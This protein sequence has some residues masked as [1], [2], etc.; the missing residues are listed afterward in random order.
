MDN[1]LVQ[2]DPGLF[3]WTILTFLVLLTLLAK[4]AWRTSAA[5]ARQPS[6][7]RSASRS[8]MPSR[9]SRSWSGCSRNRR[10][11]SGRR[12]SRP[13]R[14][15]RAAAADAERLREE[16]RQKA[17]AEAETIVRNAERQIQLETET[18]APADPPRGG[19]SVGDD[20]VEDHPAESLEGRQRAADRRSA[21]AGRRPSHQ[22]ELA[23]RGS[24]AGWG[25]DPVSSRVRL[26]NF[27][28]SHPHGENKTKAAKPHHRNVFWLHSCLVCTLDDPFGVDSRE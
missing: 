26:A 17:R 3:I 7:R 15:S 20:R 12:G 8:T 13:S 27:V 6:G 1:P 5:G 19:R 4:F 11:S 28:G 24:E 10:R 21:Q 25:S 2:P 23:A 14:S 9:P 16:M 22:A 18:R